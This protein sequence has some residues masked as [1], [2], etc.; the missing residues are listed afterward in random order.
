MSE[1]IFITLSLLFILGGIIEIIQ[2][3]LKNESKRNF[4]IAGLIIIIG[5]IISLIGIYQNIQTEKIT[6]L[7]GTFKPINEG[8]YSNNITCLLGTSSFIFTNLTSDFVEGKQSINPF[9]RFPGYDFSIAIRR[10]ENNLLISAEFY[11]LDGKIVA[12][13]IDNEWKI[14]PNNYFEKNYDEYALEVIDQY[15]IPNLQVEL[16]DKNTIRLGGV[17]YDGQRAI[18]IS[19]LLQ[20]YGNITEKEVIEKGRKIDTLFVYPAENHLGERK[21]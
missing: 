19:D 11:S 1:I 15:G 9:Y 20:F 2:A 14:N 12:E 3:Y 16:V 10:G 6:A 5:I 7:S 8:E 4:I 17:F 13:L 18:I 21:H